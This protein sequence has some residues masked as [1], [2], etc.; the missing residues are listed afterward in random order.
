MGG[1]P[2]EPSHHV[3]GYLARGETVQLEM[4]QHWARILPS[5]AAC[6]IG[7]I[8]VVIAGFFAPA[9]MGFLANA[10][11][12]LW[13]VLI[14]V[15]IM[16]VV[17]WRDDTFVVTSKRIIL[18]HGIII[19]KV[20]MMPL[21]AVTDMSYNRSIIARVLG[22][23]TFVMESAGQDQALSTID[24]VRNPDEQYRV[25]CALIFGTEEPDDDSGSADSSAATHSTRH[26]DTRTPGHLHDA[27]TPGHPHDARTP[28]LDT[29]R[30][31]GVRVRGNVDDTDPYGIPVPG[32]DA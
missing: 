9:W 30:A 29:P 12:W 7:F 5:S 21:G 31:T 28:G 15:L 6:V 27:R 26:D 2:Q 24:F 20:A 32:R 3:K 17:E 22:Y 4:R 19:K 16:R 1:Q 11:W 8:L 25:V 10:A 18:V 14:G 13:F 23:G